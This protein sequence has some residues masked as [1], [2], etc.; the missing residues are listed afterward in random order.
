MAPDIYPKDAHNRRLADHVHPADWVNPEPADRYN[1]AVIGA[2]TAGLVTA[3]DRASEESTED[4]QGCDPMRNETEELFIHE[5]SPFV[6]L[7]D[8]EKRM[9]EAT[10]PKAGGGCRMRV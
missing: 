6:V 5:A 3:A 7:T 8:G 9:E 10:P 4:G 2:G 1:L